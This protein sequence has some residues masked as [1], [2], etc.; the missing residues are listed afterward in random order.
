M[1]ASGE[2]ATSEHQEHLDVTTNQPQDAS[3]KRK[4]RENQFRYNMNHTYRG[5]FVIFNHEV[6]YAGFRFDH[7][8]SVNLI[9]NW[10]LKN[11]LSLWIY[12][13]LGLS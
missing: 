13:G 1:D 3:S 9:I 11:W 4:R 12:Y 10:L 2:G 5:C 8:E 7:L 6:R